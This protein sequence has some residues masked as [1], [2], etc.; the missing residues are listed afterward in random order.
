[1]KKK[2]LN[3]RNK[4]EKNAKCDKDIGENDNEIMSTMVIMK[5]GHAKGT[6]TFVRF[7]L[8]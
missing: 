2:D 6:T 3:Q 4:K 8:S 7:L 5:L 1:M